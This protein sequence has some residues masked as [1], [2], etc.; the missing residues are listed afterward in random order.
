[1]N[2]MWNS[3]E[4]EQDKLVIFHISLEKIR[5]RSRFPL[6]NVNKFREVIMKSA[7]WV[8][9]VLLDASEGMHTCACQSM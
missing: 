5:L 6:H 9:A 4:A 7:R 2:C 3:F 1:M 8:S